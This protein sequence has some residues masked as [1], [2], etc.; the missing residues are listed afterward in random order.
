MRKDERITR[1]FLEERKQWESCLAPD[2]NIINLTWAID[3]HF[4]KGDKKIKNINDFECVYDNLVVNNEIINCDNLH[5]Y[6]ES[7]SNKIGLLTI[8]KIEKRIKSVLLNY[9]E[10]NGELK[11]CIFVFDYDFKSHLNVLYNEFFKNE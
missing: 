10:P 4:L 2:I 3:K 5:E 8:R 7:L 6:K 11:E 9:Y 1:I